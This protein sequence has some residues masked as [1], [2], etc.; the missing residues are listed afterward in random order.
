MNTNLNQEERRRE[1]MSCMQHSSWTQVVR[2][3]G[4]GIIQHKKLFSMS[5][6]VANQTL[7][8]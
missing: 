2:F 1:S 4:Y 6:T 5:D 8:I 3:I 7:D